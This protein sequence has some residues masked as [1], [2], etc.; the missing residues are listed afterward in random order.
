MIEAG[1]GTF[2]QKSKNASSYNEALCLAERNE[3][4]IDLR[5]DLQTTISANPIK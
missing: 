2:R 1:T 3:G 4:N 5:K